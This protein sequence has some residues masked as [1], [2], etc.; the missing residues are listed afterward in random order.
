M[1]NN[2]FERMTN[3]TKKAAYIY[4]QQSELSVDRKLSHKAMQKGRKLARI[5]KHLA[6]S[7]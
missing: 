3:N 4:N 1:N 5:N 7:L 6:K 2:N